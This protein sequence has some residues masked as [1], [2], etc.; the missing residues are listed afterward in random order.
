MAEQHV[1][2]QPRIQAAA[3]IPNA[4]DGFRQAMLKTALETIPQLTE[5]N[6]SIWKDKMTA[7]LK[8]R[9]VLNALENSAIPLGESDD[10]E[11]VMLLLS[12]MDSVTHNNVVTAE[13]RDSAQKIWLSMIKERFA[14]SQSS[15]RARM[16]NDF[17]YVKFQEDSVESF[18]TDIKV[19][20]KKL[21]D[22]GIELPQDILAYL[23]LF[24][25]PNS[26]QTLKRQ[27]MH[28]DK[29]LDVEYVCNHLIQFN[30][31][32]RAESSRE[33]GSTTEAALF[34]SKGK[35]S[36]KSQGSDRTGSSQNNSS[37]RCRNGFHNP[38]QD[39]NHSSNNCWHLHP[40]TAPDWWKESQAQWKATQAQSKGSKDKSKENYFISLLTR[41]IE[42][43]DPKHR[44]IL[45]SGATAHIFNDTRFFESLNL[46]QSDCIKTGKQ[47]A[48]L[49][50]K[51]KGSVRLKWGKRTIRLENC[52]FVPTIVINLI[53]AG[54][55]DAL[56]CTLSARHSK[57]SVSKNGK[58]ALQGQINNGL[59]SVD[60]PDEVGNLLNNPMANVSP[61]KETL[62]EVHEK[63]GH[64]SIQRIES[65]L[66]NSISTK[67]KSDFEC[68][69]CI[70]SKLTKQQFSQS[71][72][73]VSKPF[74]R[75]HLDLIGP[76]N[77]ESSLKHRY[78]LTVVD[79][80][81]GYLAGFPLVHKDDTTNILIKLIE[82]EQNRWGYYP[83]LVCSDGG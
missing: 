50:I 42:T 9:G 77:P 11:L 60:N 20:I 72:E 53:S 44:I 35:A 81:L 26:L 82:T 76:I 25:F 40:E 83:T 29:E 41:W 45:D 13:N 70:V 33:K 61:E 32:S 67:E 8:L 16:F 38:K 39:E 62:K 1:P 18:V 19:A 64:P 28:S 79:N 23:I 58:L 4:G 54:E 65:L 27:I 30:N 55:L 59:F 75:I 37:K 71:S 56:G 52:L 47:G 34:S 3:I 14:S 73:V 48:T 17:L 12:K 15:N 57:F 5:E 49:P 46:K 66:D 80:H 31:E 24:K 21:V 69:L 36:G 74:E 7:L 22:V 63:F 51:G 6:H 2:G 78:I 68:K 10:A 43:G